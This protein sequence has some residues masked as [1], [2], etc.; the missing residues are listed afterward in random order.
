M[1]LATPSPED[2]LPID[3]FTQIL[4]L[5]T[6][7]AP[8]DTPAWKLARLTS[9]KLD[10]RA[11]Q[12]VEA[13]EGYATDEDFDELL[14]MPKVQDFLAQTSHDEPTSKAFWLLMRMRYLGLLQRPHRAP[15]IQFSTQVACQPALLLAE[16]YQLPN[17]QERLR[18][19]S[20]LAFC[21]FVAFIAET[22][23]R[24]LSLKADGGEFL[25]SIAYD[26]QNSQARRSIR[27]TFLVR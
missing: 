14:F 1:A 5:C 26:Q 15:V 21:D 2:V 17:V 6:T 4:K 20:R 22:D 19:L 27:R 25:S 3:R 11:I 8:A 10:L 18:L 7:P 24:A 12:E 13:M 23:R 9:L 16:F